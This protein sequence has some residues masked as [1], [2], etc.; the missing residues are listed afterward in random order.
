[1]QRH[2]L[3][4][5]IPLFIFP[6]CLSA[7]QKNDLA[8]QGVKGHV[9]SMTIILNYITDSAG[10]RNERFAAKS[11]FNY[12]T[13]GNL[14][15]VYYR[16]QTGGVNSSIIYQY[17]AK[18]LCTGYSEFTKD[19]LVRKRVYTYVKGV[20]TEY[21]EYLPS[22]ILHHRKVFYPDSTGWQKQ[23]VFTPDDKS[24]NVELY[25]FD[26]NDNVL[27][28]RTRISEWMELKEEQD[29]DSHGYMIAKRDYAGNNDR[30]TLQ[31]E[32][33]LVLDSM[34]CAV[35]RTTIAHNANR[36]TDVTTSTY[37]YDKV[38]NTLVQFSYREIHGSSQPFQV[39]RCSYR[40]Y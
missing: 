18:G 35:K 3:Y 4:L 24:N 29:F 40:Y 23:E 7:K 6:Y 10:I 36:Y 14:L 13:N 33:I 20:K 39:I 26:S 19:T 12:N 2:W 17:D 32:E 16:N 37:K 9:K 34:G 38:G 21:K 11:E 28:R 5:L 25:Q 15:S 31:K 22:G 1:M 30:F 8:M 27:C